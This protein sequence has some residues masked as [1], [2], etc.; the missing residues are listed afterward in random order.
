MKIDMDV[1][2]AFLVLFQTSALL[3]S[4]PFLGQKTLHS[5]FQ[6]NLVRVLKF[7]TK[8]W[9]K[10]NRGKTFNKTTYSYWHLC[11]LMALFRISCLFIFL[12]AHIHAHIEVCS[13]NKSKI[14]GTAGV[15]DFNK[16]MGN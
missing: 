7:F 12:Y 2:R 13:F 6:E 10:Q 15:Q 14:A 8:D 11:L 3:P 9:D 4:D 5:F 1:F 16:K